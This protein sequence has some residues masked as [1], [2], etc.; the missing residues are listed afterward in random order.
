MQQI[1]VSA[2]RKV[3]PKPEP[4]VPVKRRKKVKK[5]TSKMFTTEDG[6]MGKQSIIIALSAC[7]V[8]YILYT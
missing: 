6:A 7:P 2:K 1:A 4:P 3:E 8:K 5:L